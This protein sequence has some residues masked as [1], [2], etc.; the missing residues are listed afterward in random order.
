MAFNIKFLQALCLSTPILF[1]I[2][3]AAASDNFTNAMQDYYQ[4]SQKLQAQLMKA[5]I[6]ATMTLKDEPNVEAVKAQGEAL[7]KALDEFENSFAALA[8][9]MDQQSI[10]SQY[11]T[12][13]GKIHQEEIPSSLPKLNSLSEAYSKFADSLQSQMFTV[14]AQEGWANS[15]ITVEQGNYI[16]V[17]SEG[18]WQASSSYDPTDS[19]GY[20]CRSDA[21]TL[22]SNAPLGALL[23]RVRGS[24]SV[25]GHGLHKQHRGQADASGRLEF[26]MNDDKRRNNSGQLTLQVIVMDHEDL[27]ALAEQIQGMEN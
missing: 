9:L 4:T 24:A 6:V 14:Y 20:I 12:V 11:G 2:S 16:W 7:P 25:N 3:T 22:N 18:S 10:K 15:G 27:Q 23:Y 8:K 13:I 1:S 17:N 5:V 19:E 26:I 21:Y